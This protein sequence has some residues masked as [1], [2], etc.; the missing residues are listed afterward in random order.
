MIK[1]KPV[2]FGVFFG[3]IGFANSMVRGDM[4]D[5][6]SLQAWETCA[7]CH[8]VDGNS[9]MA[10]FPKLAGQPYDYLA[11]QLRD[12]KM[13]RRQNDGGMMSGITEAKSMPELLEAARY[14]SGLQAPEPSV[15]SAKVLKITKNLFE[16]GDPTRG[17]PGC[18][19]CHGVD[20]AIPRLQAQHADYLQK[21]LS[22]FRNSRRMNDN[23]GVMQKIAKALTT[24]EIKN[25]AQYIARQ[26]RVFKS[27]P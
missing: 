23:N 12:F 1:Y 26:A 22:D 2:L 3:V 20:P 9:H 21:Q 6:G 13:K 19:Q 25:L 10:K 18:G 15:N 17:I 16:H 24:K 27:A 5:T 4:I 14:F 7:M 8:G 11:K